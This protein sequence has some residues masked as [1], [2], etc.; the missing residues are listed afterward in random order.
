MHTRPALPKPTSHMH[1]GG[2]GREKAALKNAAAYRDKEHRDLG[3]P[4]SPVSIDSSWM[5]A[6]GTQSRVDWETRGLLLSSR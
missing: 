3:D 5:C 4:R 6:Q 1:V 2:Q